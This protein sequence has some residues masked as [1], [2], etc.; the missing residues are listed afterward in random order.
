MDYLPELSATIGENPKISALVITVLLFTKYVFLSFLT[1]IDLLLLFE[2]SQPN[3][4]I[5]IW[6][7]VQVNFSLVGIFVP[8]KFPKSLLFF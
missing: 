2:L 5:N 4:F 1:D 7:H 8:N 6:K 3:F